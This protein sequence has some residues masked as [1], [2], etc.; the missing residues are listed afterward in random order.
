MTILTWREWALYYGYVNMD[1][2]N[3]PTHALLKPLAIVAFGLTA[4][5]FVDGGNLR[6]GLIVSAAVALS[7]LAKPSLMIC[8]LPAT[9]VVA[10]WYW[11]RGRRVRLVYLGGAILLP[12]VVVLGWE[13]LSYFAP[14]GRSSIVFAPFMVMAHY[15]TGLGAKFVMSILLPLAVV[16]VYGRHVFDD[17]AMQL[18][19]VQF[20]IAVV[21]TYLLAETRDPLAGNFAWT[22]QIAN[23]LLFVAST[24]FVLRHRGSP[25]RTLPCALAFGL[26]AASGVL[27]F[28][29]PGSTGTIPAS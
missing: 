15:A 20:G 27:F 23:Y 3:S 7:T 24:I 16:C 10:G 22:G 12:A 28:F 1:P 21:Y 17:P 5:A 2:Y 4:K 6:D 11:V 9:V 8:L 19:W 29:F 26:H 13:Y 18:A 25:S 14:G